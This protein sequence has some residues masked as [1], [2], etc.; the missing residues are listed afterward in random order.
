MRASPFAVLA[1]ALAT[2]FVVAPHPLAATTTTERF[3]EVSTLRGALR[4]AFREYW[5]SGARDLTPNLR[6]V[7]DY[8]SRYHLAKAAIAA[9]LLAVLVVLGIV[10]WRAFLRTPPGMRAAALASAGVVVTML[11]LFSVVLVV[12]NVQGAVAPFASL[13]PMLAAGGG[14]DE[15]GRR[16]AA[17]PPTGPLQVMV[18]DFALYH[19]AIA[20]AGAVV[21]VGFATVSV[22]AW[23]RWAGTPRPDRR[24]RR[25]LGFCGV[26]FAGAA[27]LMAVVVVANAGTAMD[28]E[29][30]LLAFFEGGW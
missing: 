12:A 23:R 11:A 9:L 25:L 30:A 5:A 21:V 22:L 28:P 15:A 16:L 20:V 3:A 1:A 19:A 18:G 6:T 29:P 8:W 26:L 27:L 4:E 7:V 10:L 14:F 17:S 24:V 13:L 2:A